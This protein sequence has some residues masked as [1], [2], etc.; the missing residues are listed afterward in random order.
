MSF[1]DKNQQKSTNMCLLQPMK[2][3]HNLIIRQRKSMLIKE[4]VELS[5]I[6]LSIWRLVRPK[7]EHTSH[8]SFNIFFKTVPYLQHSE[9]L[10]CTDRTV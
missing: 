3:L 7:N 4:K 2:E 9:N 10:Y 5:S 1:F 6:L 8:N